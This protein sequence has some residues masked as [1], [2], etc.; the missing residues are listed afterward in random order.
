ML[1]QASQS[2]SIQ[3]LHSYTALTRKEGQEEK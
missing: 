3:T 1:F 2:V